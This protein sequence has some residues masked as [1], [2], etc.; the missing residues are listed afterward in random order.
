MIVATCQVFGDLTLCIAEIFG[1]GIE[2]D[3]QKGFKRPRQEQILVT[4]REM[5]A[6]H[7]PLA[8]ELA[9]AEEDDL[10]SA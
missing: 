7:E 8:P 10:Q 4:M 3:T 1:D 9:C 6:S 2:P 5:Q